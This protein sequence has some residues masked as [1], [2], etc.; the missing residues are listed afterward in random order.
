MFSAVFTEKTA[1][2]LDILKKIASNFTAKNADNNV[3]ISFCRTFNVFVL[4]C[5][6]KYIYLYNELEIKIQDQNSFLQTIKKIYQ[7]LTYNTKIELF[8]S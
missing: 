3:A 1:V 7:Y 2:Q 6:Y 8:Q 4:Q 5:I